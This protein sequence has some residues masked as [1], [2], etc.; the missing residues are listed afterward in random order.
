MAWHVG[1]VRRGVVAACVAALAG[2]AG[3]DIGVS[4]G[5]AS[6]SGTGDAST[7]AE[8]G[9]AS[10]TGAEGSGGTT[11]SSGEPETS[12]ASED[13]GS[14]FDSASST[15]PEFVC[16]DDAIGGSEACDGDDLGGEDCASQGFDGGDLACADD[17]SALDT[18]ECFMFEG[19]CCEADGT[20]G[21][22]DAECTAAVC[23]ADPSCCTAGWDGP[24]ATAAFDQPA[25]MDVGG[26]C[27][28]CA[29][30]AAE[31]AEVCDGADLDG[32]DCT[33]VGFDDG[34]LA[35]AGDCTDFDTSACIDWSGD[36]C[37]ADA[38]PGCD[39]NA[40]TTAICAIDA[41]CC[42]GAWDDA[43]AALALADPSCLNVGG[44]CPACGDDVA[45]GLE[46]CDGADLQGEDCTDQGF[47]GG[48]LQCADD[49]LALDLS[50]CA[51]VGFGDC[52][53]NSPDVACL[54]SEQCVTDLGMPPSTGVC[55]DAE[56]T[57]AADCPL[58]PPGGTAPVVCIDVTGEGINECILLCAL[59]QTCPTGMHCELN[60]ACAWAAN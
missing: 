52:V 53:N 55:T 45:E 6:A 35:C 33:T 28:A 26:S 5:S 47:D 13:S 22:D 57:T 17:C 50:T 34:S 2:C 38:T 42:D 41:S 49:C 19:P 59:G 12:G 31:G 24:C 10:L 60:L 14:T 9:S 23:A 44:S 11:G 8:T 37:A 40:C 4:G 25:C 36:C 46:A 20:P 15:G 32:Q 48:T 27:P 56:C 16:G 39:D 51:D 18:A 7:G 54:A 29:D 43:C 1:A 21:C 58:A 3:D 30:G